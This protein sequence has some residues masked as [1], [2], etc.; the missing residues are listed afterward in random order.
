MAKKKNVSRKKQRKG[1]KARKIHQETTEQSG[2]QGGK[3]DKPKKQVATDENGRKITVIMGGEAEMEKIWDRMQVTF[4][5]Q[6]QS[7]TISERLES[8]RSAIETKSTTSDQEPETFK[9][10]E[11]EAEQL[12]GRMRDAVNANNRQ[13]A[14]QGVQISDLVSMDLSLMEDLHLKEVVTGFELDLLKVTMS[15]NW[16]VSGLH[17]ATQPVDPDGLDCVPLDN[18]RMRLRGG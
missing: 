16:C 9:K 15:L 3:Q 12:L 8:V 6:S 4:A 1:T 17:Q 7:S 18:D 13:A 5:I 2:N 14:Q 11:D 10:V